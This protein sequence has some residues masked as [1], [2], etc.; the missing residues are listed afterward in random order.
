[1]ASYPK[2]VISPCPNLSEWHMPVPL[3][4]CQPPTTGSQG[5]ITGG[6]LVALTSILL[7][8]LP[9]APTVPLTPLGLASTSQPP[10][11][12]GEPPRNEHLLW[13]HTWNSTPFPMVP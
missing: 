9:G 8:L 5:P 10:T 1:M 3:S 12:P 11:L 6:P 2:K 4:F 13:E 7:A